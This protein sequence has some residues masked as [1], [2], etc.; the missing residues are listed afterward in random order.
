MFPELICLVLDYHSIQRILGASIE[1]REV[2]NVA[3][4]ISRRHLFNLIIV[5]LEWM[6]PMLEHEKDNSKCPQ[7]LLVSLIRWHIRQVFR[8]KLLS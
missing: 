4:G 2:L 1:S 7:I 5:E 8:V 6:T 3:L